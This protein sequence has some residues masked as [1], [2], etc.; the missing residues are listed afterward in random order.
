MKTYRMM[1]LGKD[2]EGVI[3]WLPTGGLFRITDDGAVVAEGAAAERLLDDLGVD[4]EE[5]LLA[6]ARRASYWGL[7]EEA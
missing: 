3:G 4:T 1:A 6:V 7:K 5:S 2:A